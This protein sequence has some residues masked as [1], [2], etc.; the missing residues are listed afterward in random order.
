[1]SVTAAAPER[2]KASCA[3][4]WSHP[5]VRILV[6]DQLHPG[7]S[8]LTDRALDLLAVPFGERILDLGCG[9]GGTAARAA[10]RGHRVVALDRSL[11][12]AAEARTTSGQGALA[13]DAEC[14]PFPS[15]CMDGAVAECV[16][17]ALPDKDA[18]IR[19]VARVLRPGGRFVLADVTRDG[20]LPAELDTLVAWLAC[21]GGALGAERYAALMGDA[22]LEVV[23]IE[24]HGD[25]LVDLLDQVRRRLALF[26][27]AVTT[28][29]VDGGEVGLP[30][31]LLELGQRLLTVAREAAGDGAL[32]YALIAARA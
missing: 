16:I 23:A 18:A 28:G 10:A 25:A 13:A 8:E 12:L 31:E 17:S 1:M 24:S 20:P 2:V 4:L 3:E 32:S 6:G 22:G 14:L 5:G 30:G 15:R 7:G 9:P 19:E 11:S 29:V 27:A 21:A 26:Q